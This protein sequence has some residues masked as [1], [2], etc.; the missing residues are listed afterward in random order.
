M[1]IIN[2][3]PGLVSIRFGAKGPNMSQ[4]SACSTGA[5]AIGEAARV[6]ERGDADAMICGGAEATIS[7]LGVGGFN[8]CARCRR[9][10]TRPS[11]RHARSTERDGF[12]IGEGAGVLVL[13]ELEHAK[14]RGAKIYA[15]LRGYAPTPTRTTSRPRRRRARA[16]SAACAWR[17]RTRS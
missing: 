17:W 11:R 3:A 13:E 5:H 8:A 16:R 2:L 1:I 14:K 7:P 6:I 4:V 15:E 10:T 12:V 9:A